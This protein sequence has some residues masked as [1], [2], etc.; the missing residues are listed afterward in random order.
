MSE[1][2]KSAVNITQGDM[3]LYLTAF[4]VRDF[5][6]EAFYRVDRLNVAAAQG[7]QRLLAKSRVK[8]FGTDII[9]AHTRDEALLPTSVL[10]ATS[11]NINFNE[12]NKDI[13]F[14]AAPAAGVCPFNT[15]DGQHRIEGLCAAARRDGGREL[16]DF[17]VPAVIAP[18]LSEAEQMLLFI[19]V[20]AKQEKVGAEVAQH[21]IS[22]FTKMD[23]IRDLPYIPQWLRLDIDRGEIQR[24]LD[25]V[26]R[27]NRDADSPL[28][29]RVQMAD[30]VN[31]RAHHINQQSL[32]GLLVRF[33]LTP[34]HPLSLHHGHDLDRQIAIL[35]NFWR[36]V[37]AVFVGEYSD[38]TSVFKMN[39]MNFFLMILGP[40]LNQLAK[41]GGYTTEDFEQC[42][43]SADEYLEVG[44]HTYLLSPEYWK[45]GGNAGMLNAGG[46]RK[47]AQVFNDALANANNQ[48]IEI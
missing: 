24:A 3:R 30:E 25:I 12:S 37:A 39:S 35:K 20:N 2:H 5:L 38:R 31:T 44:G 1:I 14:D 48:D 29:G 15:V 11:G 43:R 23:G 18:N 47:I 7:M 46:M 13:V 19:V 6:R 27:L 10:L 4:T 21:I 9:A 28:C 8:Q 41:Q 17:P 22:R 42:M 34:A 26:R 33:V 36:A 45:T 32:V 40:V 16:L